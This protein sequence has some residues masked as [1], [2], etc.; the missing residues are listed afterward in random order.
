[1]NFVSAAPSQLENSPEVH[2]ATVTGRIVDNVSNELL[3]R[4]TRSIPFLQSIPSW[5]LTLLGI[6]GEWRFCR[7]TRD[8]ASVYT[9]GIDVV[10]QGLCADDEVTCSDY[11]RPYYYNY[12]ER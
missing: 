3:V 1:M 10:C 4:K 6:R 7:H 2:A 8:G 12:F 11:F 9:N 5:P